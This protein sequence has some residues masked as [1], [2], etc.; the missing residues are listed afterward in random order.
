MAATFE[1]IRE[2]KEKSIDSL[3]KK[4]NVVGAGIGR[5]IQ[6]GK[7]TDE[8][9]LRIYVEKKIARSQLKKKDLIK[10]EIQ[11]VKT[12]VIG[13][14]KLRFQQCD[15]KT[16]KRPA[17]GG[18]SSGSCHSTT[19]GY[20]SAGTLGCVVIDRGDGSR[21]ILSNNHVFADYDSDT[22]SR[23]NVGDPLVQPGTLDGG[24][25]TTA[26]DR[27][28]TLKRWVPFNSTGDNLVDAALGELINGTD[29]SDEIGCD[30]GRVQGIRELTADDID[31]LQV[32]KCGR[33]TCYTTGTVTDIDVTVNVGYEVE[34]V[35]NVYR[36]VHQILTTAMSTSGDSG[37]LILDM[38]EK[39][40][41]LLF[42]GSDAVTVGTPI[43]TVLDELNLEFP[44]PPIHCMIGGPDRL[45]RVG[46]PGSG[47]HCIT[48]GPD[49]ICR[50]GGPGMDIHCIAGG[51]DRL[52]R[53]G[54][55][56]S[57]V[58]CITGGPDRICRIGGP[59]TYHC[60]IGGPDRLQQFC[61]IGGPGFDLPVCLACGPDSNIG[62]GAGGPDM[63]I[64]VARCSAGPGL[65][66]EFRRPIDDLR[67][68]VV[69]DMDQIPKAM[70]RALQKMLK[71]IAEER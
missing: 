44:T 9:C 3:L 10:S 7:V 26:A 71:Q 42:A 55:P 19:Y 59:G 1:K 35:E 29:V 65:D 18:D 38:N 11:K 8:L 45:C 70:Q 43:Q 28:A 60:R 16:R 50:V 2:I 17:F 14:G 31:T 49:R 56:G 63:L 41:A 13:I 4:M 58:H 52:C 61:K 64:D 68:L 24:T 25:C 67:K 69:L 37:S 22:A 46:G 30:I 51:P 36:F 12:D 15:Q 6:D 20:I 21:C 66:I 33:T 57:E 39:A 40:V 27:I 47:M 54:G 53:V 5:K 34:G 23:A 32:Q 62:C 48:G